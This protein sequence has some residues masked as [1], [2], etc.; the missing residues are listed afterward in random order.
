LPIDRKYLAEILNFS[1]ITENSYDTVAD[2]DFIID[3]CID[4]VILMLHLSRISEDIIIWNTEEFKFIQ[5]PDKFATGSSIM[6]QKKNPD[7]FELIRGKSASSIGHLTGLLSLIK[8]LPMS[9]NR[10]L[11]E[12]KRLFFPVIEDVFKSLEILI[13]SV[14]E[15]KFNK[16]SIENKISDF[17]LSTDIAEYLVKKGVPFRKAH[18][19]T[20]NIVKYC[21]DKNK[22]LKDL[23]IEEFK[24]FSSKFSNDI[25][26]ILDFKNSINSK[27]SYGSTSLNN[28]KKELRR[29]KKKLK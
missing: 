18:Y 4:C 13:L 24:K 23:K 15:I 25:K 7:I 6:P 22:K 19:I 8:G 2:R 27:V 28:I 21:L 5:L 26:E 20:G 14:P 9:Y 10:D 3:V 12:D 1:G 29:W 17:T 11:Q 16:K